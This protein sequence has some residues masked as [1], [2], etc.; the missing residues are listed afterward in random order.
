MGKVIQS[1]VT[2]WPGTVTLSDPLSFPQSFAFEDG[3]EAAAAL[4][5]KHKKSIRRNH[6]ALLPGVCACVEAWEL[7][8]LPEVITPDNFPSTPI[9]DAASLCA[10][11][12]DAVLELHTGGGDPNA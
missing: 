8:G 11:L 7:K 6:A 3:L 4:P 10:W 2:R 5:E 1:P 9:E 12:I